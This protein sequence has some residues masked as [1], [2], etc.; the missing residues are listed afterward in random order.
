MTSAPGVVGPGV[1]PAAIAAGV[2]LIV[3]GTHPFNT[4]AGSLTCAASLS[5]SCREHGRRWLVSTKAPLR[6]LLRYSQKWMFGAWSHVVP[7]GFNCH[8]TARTCSSIALFTNTAS[9]YGKRSGSMR[10]KYT[11]FAGTPGSRVSRLP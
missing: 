8:P 6:S 9:L 4:N 10:L 2:A 11:E 5:V 7:L 3:V 1:V